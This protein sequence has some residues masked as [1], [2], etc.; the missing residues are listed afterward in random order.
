MGI[1]AAAMISSNDEFLTGY[2]IPIEKVLEYI[3][4]YIEING[5]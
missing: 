1:N 2:A 4:L 5:G 3:D